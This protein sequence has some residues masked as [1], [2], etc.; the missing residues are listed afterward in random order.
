MYLRHRSGHLKVLQTKCC[1][2]HRRCLAECGRLG[3]GVVG[4]CR[5]LCTAI[6]F[7][8]ALAKVLAKVIPSLTRVSPGQYQTWA[9]QGAR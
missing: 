1:G 3:R 8:I 7:K 4:M 2:L 9:L 6:A 5:L